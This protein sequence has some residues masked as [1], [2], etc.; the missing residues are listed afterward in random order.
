MRTLLLALLTA[1]PALATDLPGH[2]GLQLYSLRSIPAWDAKLDE[3]KT[4][5]YHVVEGGSLPAGVTAPQY[6]AALASRHLHMVSMH[7]DYDR[8]VR[9]LPGAVAEA[10]AL[11]VAFICTPWIPHEGDFTAA[12]ADQAIANFNRWGAAFHAAVITYCYHPHG[13]EFPP[14]ADG[15]TLFDRIAQGTKPENLSFELDV[16][17]AAKAGQDPTALMEQ[18]GG[19]W[20]LMHLKDIGQGAE[21]HVYTGKAPSSDDVAV[22]TGAVDWAAVL[23]KAAS[24]GIRWYFI[25]DESEDPLQNL[26]KS[27]AYLK[28]LDR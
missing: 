18:Y 14:Q 26:P 23:H 5:G 24:E 25:E 15:A 27:L 22:G 3:A 13:Y 1:L 28:S 11:G 10:Q 20:A 7:V 17:W 19:R 4:L 21:T 12:V 2:L 6:K 16:F 8:L 9:D